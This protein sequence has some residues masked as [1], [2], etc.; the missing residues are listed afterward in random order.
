MLQVVREVAVKPLSSG[1]FFPGDPFGEG[2]RL[3]EIPA[4]HRLDDL[5]LGREV[6]E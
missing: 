3:V 4:E 2:H 1:A 6:M 5:G